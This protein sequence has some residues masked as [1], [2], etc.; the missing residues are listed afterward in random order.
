SAQ[1]VA[2]RAER[3]R[4]PVFWQEVRRTEIVMLGSLPFVT[5]YTTLGFSIARYIRYDFDSAYTPNPF[6]KA[7][8]ALAFSQEEQM[9]ILITSL[10]ISAG[11]GLTDLTIRLVKRSVAHRRAAREQ[12][13]VTVT[14]IALDAAAVRLPPP[15]V[16]VA[17]LAQSQN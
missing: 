1:T 4:V 15:H 12:E 10:C 16:V 7:S 13:A 8:S 3:G 17:K 14:P 6:A 2:V 11:I 5:L 9:K